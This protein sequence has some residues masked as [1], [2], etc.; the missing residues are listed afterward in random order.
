MRLRRNRLKAY[1]LKRYQS[2][3]DEEGN[4]IPSFSSDSIE[5]DAEI[6]P[7]SGQ[8]QVQM[9]GSRL[10]YILNM[11][12]QGTVEIH[13][14]DGIC[15]FNKEDPDYRVISIKTYTEHQF[16]ELEKI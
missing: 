6:W 4:I 10:N 5:I 16:I 1:Q 9:Y 7:A 15:V 11:L 13:E 12:Y 8:L 3:K 14:R 2:S